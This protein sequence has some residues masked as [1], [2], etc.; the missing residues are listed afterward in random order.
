M[1]WVTPEL[2]AIL[3]EHGAQFFASKGEDREKVVDD[4][5]ALLREAKDDLPEVLST[6]VKTWYNNEINLFR[7]P[8][9]RDVDDTRVKIK[10]HNAKSVAKEVYGE[11]YEEIKQQLQDSG[12]EWND[13]YRET[14]KR[15]WGGLTDKQQTKCQETATSRNSGDVSE[16]EKRKLATAN[17]NKEVAS[18]VKRMHDIYG[19]R[20][21][22]LT[23]WTDPTGNSQTSVHETSTSP[24]F[25]Q[26]FPNWKTQKNVANSFL[27]YS[28]FFNDPVDSDEE[29]QEEVAK[30]MKYPWA[31]LDFHP[32]DDEETTPNW[33][34]YPILPDPPNK[35]NSE[36]IGGYK[37][38][39]RAFVKAVYKL[40]IGSSHPPWSSMSTP[41]GAQELIRDKFLPDG[42]GLKDPSRMVK[43]EVEAFQKLWMGR[44]NRDKRPLDFKEFEAKRKAAEAREVRIASLTSKKRRYVEIA[45]GSD[46]D[47]DGTPQADKGP[48]KKKTKPAAA[49]TS[50]VNTNEKAGKKTAKSAEKPA[51]P[52]PRPVLKPDTR[53]EILLGLST[54][55][56]YRLL[57]KT[58]LKS[59][60]KD[61]AVAKKKGRTPSWISWDTDAVKPGPEF[62]ADETPGYLS[63][64]RAIL[65]W[66]SENPHIPNVG[67]S[68]THSE[69][70]DVLLI[71]GL[72][73]RTC[74]ECAEAEPDTPL[75]NVPFGMEDKEETDQAVANMLAALTPKKALKFGVSAAVH[76]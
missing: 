44:Q 38:V 57:V 41:E 30:K 54:L 3:V 66:I 65:Q 2:K 24:K 61:T 62:F 35:K 71:V 22:C 1:G 6:K 72:T 68:F 4:V 32:E 50:A 25:S 75:Y 52:L 46:D 37:I 9:E 36:W 33:R 15:L 59:A 48:S 23:S 13:L 53:E 16:G 64:W 28:E 7:N 43:S 74:K 63:H 19:V 56:S 27:E 21:L 5:V 20:M 69:A 60:T 45:A 31:R 18:F 67:S 26:Q 55:A 58:V 49:S 73:L 12:T 17:A 10:R 11:K 47:D 76:R 40:Q 14:M 8:Q 39:I 51:R 70:S 34:G 29:E 42:L